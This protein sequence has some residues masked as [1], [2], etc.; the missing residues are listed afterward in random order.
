MEEKELQQPMKNGK[1]ILQELFEKGLIS[2]IIPQRPRS[3]TITMMK[4][5]NKALIEEQVEKPIKKKP[6]SKAKESQKML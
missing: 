6:M 4:R 1:T 2:N 3:R 5:K